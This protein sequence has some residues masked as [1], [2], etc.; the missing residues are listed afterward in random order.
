MKRIKKLAGKCLLNLLAIFL[1]VNLVS[2]AAVV[3]Q[4]SGANNVAINAA[5]SLFRLDLGG[6]LNP[7]TM[8]TFTT[9]RRE[10]NWDDIPEQSAYPNSI[11]GHYYN[12][13]SPAGVIFSTP[14]N[15]WNLNTGNFMVSTGLNPGPTRF[16]NI[17]PSYDDALR[18]YSGERIA[19]V[20]PYPGIE[21]PSIIN[22]HFFIPGTDTPATVRG[23]GIV[24]TDVD[25]AENATVRFFGVDG[26]VLTGIQSPLPANNGLSFIGV[27]YNAGERIARVEIKCGKD[28]LR[29]G[30]VDGQNGIDVVA[31]DDII[32]GE[33]HA[34]RVSSGRFRR[35]RRFRLG[36]LPPRH[37]IMVYF[38]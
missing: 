14:L 38:K 35:R 26:R 10:I 15:N 9:G 31:M 19:S 20:R 30:N 33:P 18:L 6:Q 5:V 1:L 32:Y 22:V 17:D 27:S 4:A 12:T 2:A 13:V 3:R 37:R 21:A 7:N 8:Q 16:E 23:F 34:A 11:P 25:S 29:L 24:F 28:P 36:H